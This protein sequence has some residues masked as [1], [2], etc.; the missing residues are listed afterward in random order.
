ML[1]V[2]VE[3]SQIA[4]RESYATARAL[5]HTGLAPQTPYKEGGYMDAISWVLV[6]TPTSGSQTNYS[7]FVYTQV[8]LSVPEGPST[9]YLRLLIPKTIPCIVFGLRNLKF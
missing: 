7:M 4:N 2:A 5:L 1:G 6:F 3:D 9:Q 8:L